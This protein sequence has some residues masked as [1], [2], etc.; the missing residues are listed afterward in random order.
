MF[1]SMPTTRWLVNAFIALNYLSL[2]RKKCP[3]LLHFY[4]GNIDFLCH[5]RETPVQSIRF[6]RGSV[7]LPPC[8]EDAARSTRRDPPGLINV[9]SDQ[10]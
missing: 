4:G 7:Q 5:P 9:R 6:L 1:T 10:C 8:V 3:K 2:H